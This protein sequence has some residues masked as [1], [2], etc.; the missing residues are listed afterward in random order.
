MNTVIETINI[1]KKYRRGS[2]TINALDDVNVSI[3][4]GELTAIVGPSGSGKTTF[5]NVIS[6]LDKPSQGE[7]IVNGQTCSYLTE[8]ELVRIRR[9]TYG[10]IFQYFYLMPVLTAL[11]NVELPFLFSKKKV[12]RPKAI[13]MLKQVGLA[14]KKHVP[15]NRLSGGEKQ[16][17]GIARALI[18]NPKI[19][20]ADEPTGRLNTEIRDSLLSIF[21][22]LA[23]SG[24]AFVIATHDLELAEKC[25]R[26]IYF[27][28]GR[29]VNREE[30]SLN[31][32]V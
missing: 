4:C 27:Q 5:L 31:A 32:V 10:F 19:I 9:R 2:E 21:Q 28:D 22:E 3:A 23:G 12:D 18:N 6:C 24:I 20:I 15:V 25:D 13:E 11:E 7:L 30:S 26:I 29:R 8:T 16:R 1:A 14:Q 17:V